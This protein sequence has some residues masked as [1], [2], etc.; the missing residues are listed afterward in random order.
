MNEVVN[1]N[2][3]RESEINSDLEILRS[4]GLLGD[5]VE[6]LGP[7]F[8]LSRAPEIQDPSTF[9]P[10]AMAKNWLVGEVA[11]RD[12][13]IDLLSRSIAVSSPRR[14]NVMHLSCKAADPGRAQKILQSFLDAYMVRHTAANRT[15]G[16]QVFFTEQS[17]L[18]GEQLAQIDQELRDAKNKLGMASIEGQ[19]KN[20]E[21]QANAI[22]LAVLENERTLA[23]SQ[24]RISAL[25][26]ALAELPE[27][28]LE[29]STVPSAAADD[30]R[31]EFYKVQIVQQELNSRFTDR[32]PAVVAAKQHLTESNK[33]LD[34]ETVHRTHPTH[35]LSAVRQEVQI[36]LA[37]AQAAAA[38]AGAESVVLREQQHAA[39]AKIKK[40]NEEELHIREL[41]RKAELI[42]RSYHT[43]TS[44]REQARIN[45]ALEH[46]H[47]SN[48][49]VIQ[50]PSFVTKPSVP[51]IRSAFAIA[52]V[53]ATCASV[54]VALAAEHF[55]QSLRS[56][57]QVE[58]ALGVPVLF[59]VPRGAAGVFVEN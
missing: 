29:E 4:R 16:S 11:P 57:E 56:P 43:Y 37:S 23:S 3:S 52:L 53:L 14:S 20:T 9:A 10:I 24:E 38:A 50:P 1:V 18:L 32:H 26:N 22:E 8:V 36:E 58:Q 35:K 12:Q 2:E 45:A 33:I 25:E 59:S 49:N 54:L 42:E 15:A 6:S 41:S 19:R 31:N 5:V 46:Q 47:I 13:A 17:E 7:D 48:V 40:L 28:E 44:N 21:E 27:K 34:A 39:Q 55:D 30:M 51:N